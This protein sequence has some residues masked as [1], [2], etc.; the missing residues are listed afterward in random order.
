M[1]AASPAVLPASEEAI[2][3][4]MQPLSI[5]WGASSRCIGARLRATKRVHQPHMPPSMH[6]C[7]SCTWEWD[8]CVPPAA[9]SFSTW[10]HSGTTKR[11][12]LTCRWGVVLAWITVK[13][14]GG[15]IFKSFHLSMYKISF[16]FSS[17]VCVC[18]YIDMCVCLCYHCLN[19]INC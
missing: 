1:E 16:H 13:M 18:I 6:M 12:M 5:Q 17:C 4:N 10:T 8:W 19:S 15:G 7:A 11:V 9:N 14:V 2:P 3:V